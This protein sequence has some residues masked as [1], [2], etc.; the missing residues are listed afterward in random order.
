[1]AKHSF[2][3]K[4]QV[5]N[6]YISGK[7]SYSTIAKKHGL[8]RSQVRRWAAAYKAHGDKAL[9]RSRQSNSY[10]FEFKLAA[11][12]IYLTS[13]LSYL[14]LAVQ[15]NIN[16]PSTL[17]AWVKR[18]RNGGLDALKPRKKGRPSRMTDDATKSKTKVSTSDKVVGFEN[19]KIKQLE[20]ENYQ[21]RLENAVLKEF[22]RLSSERAKKNS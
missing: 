3:L 18:Y 12:E 9:M 8:D 16:N 21:L 15:L 2:K 6:E 4:K 14:D 5:V 17:V 1:M 13:E 19:E 20:E 7:G 10:S 11:V 22:G